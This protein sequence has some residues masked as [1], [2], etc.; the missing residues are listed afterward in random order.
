MLKLINA[1]MQSVG[2]QQSWKCWLSITKNSDT[3]IL[4]ANA[5]GNTEYGALQAYFEPQEA[6]LWEIAQLEGYQDDI[7]ERTTPKALLRAL[8][9]VTLDEINALRTRAGMPAR[10]ITQLINAVRDKL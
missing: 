4:Q 1:V 8:A 3:W 5:P 7:F 2:G 6:D 9:L 10:T